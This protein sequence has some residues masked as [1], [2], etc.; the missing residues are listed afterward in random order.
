MVAQKPSAGGNW[1]LINYPGEGAG[2]AEL[3]PRT[4]STSIT[5][6]RAGSA[7]CPRLPLGVSSHPGPVAWHNHAPWSRVLQTVQGL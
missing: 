3:F 5:L 4:C 1:C 7:L 6:G 2:P